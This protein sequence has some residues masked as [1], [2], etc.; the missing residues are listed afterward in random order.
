M[1]SAQVNDK[2]PAKCQQ[3]LGERGLKR[4]S[5]IDL[6]L[7]GVWSSVWNL[8]NEGARRPAFPAVSDE[9]Y[10]RYFSKKW[11]AASLR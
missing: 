8:T 11:D 7:A 6:K 1:R 3:I 10:S 2:L 5:S 4:L 9:W